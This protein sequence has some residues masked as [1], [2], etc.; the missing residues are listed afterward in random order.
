ML[1]RDEKDRIAR[2]ERQLIEENRHRAKVRAEF[3]RDERREQY[4]NRLKRNAIIGGAVFFALVLL[5]R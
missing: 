3:Y 1:N 2:D 4:W 5:M